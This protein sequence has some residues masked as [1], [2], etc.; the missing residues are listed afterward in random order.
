MVETTDSWQN[1]R[2]LHTLG[3]SLLLKRRLYFKGNVEYGRV[4]FG[5]ESIE[6]HRRLAA[7]DYEISRRIEGRGRPNGEGERRAA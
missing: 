5:V 7:V 4:K 1:N 6:W 3:W 2:P